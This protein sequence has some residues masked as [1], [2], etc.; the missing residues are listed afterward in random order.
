[1][2]GQTSCVRN[3]LKNDHGEMWLKIVISQELKGWQD[4]ARNSNHRDREPFSLGGFNER[5]LKW[6]AVDDQV[7]LCFKTF[8]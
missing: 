3:H 7:L 4:A 2:G 8:N 6:I 1:M 5:L